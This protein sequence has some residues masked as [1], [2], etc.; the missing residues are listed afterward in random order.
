MNTNCGYIAFLDDDDEWLPE[1]LEIQTCL[2]DDSPPEVGGVCTGCFKIEKISGR[3]SIYNPGINDLSKGNFVATSTVLL[4]RECFEKCGLF[5][6]NMPTSSDYD[7]WIR[8]SKMFSFKIIKNTLAN[9]YYH[10]NRLTLN[11]EKKVIRLEIL[12]AKH[13][14]FFKQDFKAYSRLYLSLGVYYFNN[15]EVR[16]G[17]KAFSKAII[18]NQFDMRN[19]FNFLLSLLGEDR[20][21]KLKEAIRRRIPFFC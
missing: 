8:I 17:R 5:D 4:R 1:K 2:L 18:M 10:E 20:F 13:D 7:M 9:H 3:V 15:G 21:K 12:I 6:E 11:N 19:C 14:N 16:K